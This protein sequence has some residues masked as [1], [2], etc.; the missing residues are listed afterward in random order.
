MK[1]TSFSAICLKNSFGR[2]NFGHELF[3]NVH[4]KAGNLK[5]DY[6]DAHYLRSDNA[7][8]QQNPLIGNY[9]VDPRSSEVGMGEVYSSDKDGSPFGWLAGLGSGGEE[10]DFQ[11]RPRDV[12]ARKSLGQADR[13][14][15]SLG[16]RILG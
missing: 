11:Q 7:R 13:R 12:P 9:V 4:I 3:D 16:F 14:S 8:V 6:G 2:S 1:V 5:M 10:E 15:S